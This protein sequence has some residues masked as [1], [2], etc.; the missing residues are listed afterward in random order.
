[1]DEYLSRLVSMLAICL[2]T[3]LSDFTFGLFPPRLNNDSDRLH[4]GLTGAEGG[5][6]ELG[7]AEVGESPERPPHVAWN[8]MPNI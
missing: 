4:K 2:A 5:D 6:P 8:I 7:C 3:P 1:M